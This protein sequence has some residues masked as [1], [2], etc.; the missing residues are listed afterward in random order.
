[1]KLNFI[2]YLI[3]TSIY[4]IAIVQQQTGTHVCKMIDLTIA[5]TLGFLGRMGPMTRAH[6]A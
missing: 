5:F 2:L 1:M 6:Q 4:R 3:D